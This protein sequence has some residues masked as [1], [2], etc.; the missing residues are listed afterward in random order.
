[1]ITLPLAHFGH[2]YVQ[3]IFAAPVLLVAGVLGLDSVK[4]RLRN[5]RAGTH[6]GKSPA[7][8]KTKRGKKP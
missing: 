1:M 7:T 2:W 6:K 3:L 8:P 5:R 4:Q